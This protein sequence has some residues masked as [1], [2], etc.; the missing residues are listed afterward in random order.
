MTKGA[1][2]VKFSVHSTIGIGPLINSIVGV[3]FFHFLAFIL[4]LYF[5][6]LKGW[7]MAWDDLVVRQYITQSTL[8]YF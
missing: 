7:R 3:F 8:Y 4:N 6:A 1:W 2:A 5:L